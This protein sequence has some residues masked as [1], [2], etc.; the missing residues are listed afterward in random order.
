MYYATTDYLLFFIPF[1]LSVFVQDLASFSSLAFRFF[2]LSSPFPLFP[3]LSLLF[4]TRNPLPPNSLRALLFHAGESSMMDE[5][6]LEI[7]R[8]TKSEDGRGERW[9]NGKGGGDRQVRGCSI[10]IDERRRNDFKCLQKL[11]RHRRFLIICIISIALI[12]AAL[13]ICRFMFSS[14]RPWWQRRR[15]G[16]ARRWRVTSPVPTQ[17]ERQHAKI[18]IELFITF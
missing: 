6:V 13:I 12:A 1:S 18:I 11:P 17:S 10:F 4:V 9:G 5:F 3:S 16:C 2:P 8:G 7:I 14:G 15:G